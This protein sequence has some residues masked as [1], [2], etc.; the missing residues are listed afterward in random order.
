[1]A[2]IEGILFDKDGVL[3]DFQ[4][5]WGAW[6]KGVI[7]GFADGDPGLAKRLADVLDFDAEAGTFRRGSFVIAGTAQQVVDAL[8]RELPDWEPD[9]LYNHI[10]QQTARAPQVEAVRLRPTLDALKARG[11]RLGIATN[12]AEAAARAN[13]ASVDALEPF[14]FIAGSDSGFGAKPAPGMC[15][16]F[17]QAMGLPPEALVMVGDSTHDMIAARAAGFARVAVLTGVATH[18]DLAP[19]ADAVLPDIG[20]LGAWLDAR[21]E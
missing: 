13:V 9:A 7:A 21:G 20:A 1:M 8:S 12:D 19:H 17:A 6:T 10:K 5:T 2:A 16:G 3:F 14:D 18:A 15:L 4:K 11:L